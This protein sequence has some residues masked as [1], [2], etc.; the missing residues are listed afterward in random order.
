MIPFI[1]NLETSQDRRDDMVK[2]MYSINY[3]YTFIKAVDGRELTEIEYQEEISQ[4]L[5]IPIE[6]LKPTYYLHAFH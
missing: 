1:I 6:K 5:D 3:P 4:T 2:Q